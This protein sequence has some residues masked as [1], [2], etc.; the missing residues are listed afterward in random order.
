MGGISASG[1]I[2]VASTQTKE[3]NM[4][5]TYPHEPPDTFPQE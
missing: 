5:Q 4:T 3:Q 1:H 2:H